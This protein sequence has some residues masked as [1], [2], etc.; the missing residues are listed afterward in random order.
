MV[1]EPSIRRSCRMMEFVDDDVI[2]R[3]GRKSLQ[4]LDAP[5]RLDR[6]KKHLDAIE[7][8]SRQ[9]PVVPATA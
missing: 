7:L 8:Q 9:A 4:M 1:Q 2:E 3:I 5:K 6:C